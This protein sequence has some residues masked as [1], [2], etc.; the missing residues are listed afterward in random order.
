MPRRLLLLVVAIVIS[1]AWPLS[2]LWPALPAG[3]E[4]S[5]SPSSDVLMQALPFPH[6]AHRLATIAGTLPLSPG[7]VVA[8]TPADHLASAYFVI[9]M[10]LWP[11]QVS[12]VAC[13][14][15]PQ[16]EQFRAPHLPPVFTW[17][18]D[19]RPGTARPVHVSTGV[20]SQDPAALCASAFED[21]DRTGG[22]VTTR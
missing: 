5:R 16:V 3:N 4:A 10:H 11:R 7:V 8:H 15:V 12:Y 17:R 13:A 22:G 21:T 2:R 14:P 19:L 20:P 1:Q 9:A 6:A 18:I